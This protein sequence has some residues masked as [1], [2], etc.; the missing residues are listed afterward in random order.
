MKLQIKNKYDNSI[1]YECEAVNL[2]DIVLKAI[3][4]KVNLRYA[5]LSNANLSYADLSNAD[6][7]YADLSNADLSYADLSYA[8]LS[9]AYLSNANLRYA[10]L[11]NADLR[12][13]DLSNANLSYANLR[14]AYLSNA[15]LRYADLRYADLSNAN[16][17]YAN[18][19]TFQFQRHQ[20]FYTFDGTLR[21]G[22]IVLP[23]SE[24]VDTFEQIGLHE[25]YT[26]EQI[27]MYGDFINICYKHFLNN[28]WQLTNNL[29]T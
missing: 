5:D 11:S 4:E 20:A 22:C 14:Y 25:Q 9:Y 13:A 7:S 12:Y 19:M 1:I 23:I 26:D 24:W 21:I 29:I 18:L 17:R 28:T 16:L 8:D 2:T 27:D 6:L 15:N 3:Q 10:Y